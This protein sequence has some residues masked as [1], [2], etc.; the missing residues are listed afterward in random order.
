MLLHR[1]LLNCGIC[2]S[3]DSALISLRNAI[4]A[5]LRW[6]IMNIVFCVLREKNESDN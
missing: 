5:P 3:H 1:F 4:A 2:E 6:G